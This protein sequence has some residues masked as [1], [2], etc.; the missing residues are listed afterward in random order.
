MRKV[1]KS[2]TVTIMINPFNENFE[3]M[4]K[5][6]KTYETKLTIMIHPFN[7]RFDIIREI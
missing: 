3:I 6:F 4:M 7:G 5:I 2:Y 1:L